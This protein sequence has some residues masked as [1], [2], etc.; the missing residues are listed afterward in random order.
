VA[1]DTDPEDDAGPEGPRRVEVLAVTTE[2]AVAALEA[3]LRRDADVVLRAT[4][5]YHARMRARL[6]RRDVAP[7]T[8]TDAAEGVVVDP[9]ALF[10]GVPPF[11]TPDGTA[12]D[13]DP[14]EAYGESHRERHV[15][16]V[17]AWRE[18]VR[19]SRVDVATVEAAGAAGGTAFAVDVAWLG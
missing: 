3:C 6:H 18:T 11:P 4:P 17:E 5:P 12:A 9:R 19:E 13:L 14:G 1:E 10:T 2:D 7:G 15:A 8:G 16:A